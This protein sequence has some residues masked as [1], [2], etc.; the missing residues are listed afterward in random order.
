MSTMVTGLVE[1]VESYQTAPSWFLYVV[2]AR[3]LPQ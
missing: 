2:A 3:S 1:D